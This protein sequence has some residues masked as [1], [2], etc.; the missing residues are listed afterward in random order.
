MFERKL[1]GYL[2]EILKNIK[3]YKAIL[4][5]GEQFEFQMLWEDINQTLDDQFIESSSSNAISRWE[6]MTNI[7]PKGNATLEERKFTVLAKLNEQLPY[8]MPVL[9]QQLETL[10]GVGNYSI[11]LQHNIYKLTVRVA[12]TAKNS[13]DDVIA[14]LRRIVPANIEIDCSLKYNTHKILSG[15]THLQLSEDT[16]YQIRNEEKYGN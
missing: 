2:P 6:K 15:H 10:C 4:E 16:H 9:E 5:D 11:K 14:F 3:E 8:T 1:I 7:S 12:L 13:F